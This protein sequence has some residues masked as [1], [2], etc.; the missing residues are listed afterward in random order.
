[1]GAAAARLLYSTGDFDAFDRYWIEVATHARGVATV[2]FGFDGREEAGRF[3]CLS[4][5]IASAPRL[6]TLSQ[7]VAF[8][9]GQELEAG[10][11]VRDATPPCLLSRKSWRALCEQGWLEVPLGAEGATRGLEA[12]KPAM[13]TGKAKAVARAFGEPV[14]FARG[15]QGVELVT[16]ARA[17][18]PLVLWLAVPGEFEQRWLGGRLSATRGG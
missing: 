1:M 10:A 11:L 3:R 8:R 14:L 15:A 6:I 5:A 13:M 16:T 9:D 12:A 4:A 2:R 18:E 7:G 17:E